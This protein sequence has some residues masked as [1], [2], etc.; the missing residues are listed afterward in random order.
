[1]KSY[2]IQTLGDS[3]LLFGGKIDAFALGAVPQSGVVDQNVLR[4]H[5]PPL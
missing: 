4:F 2:L 1:V 3:Q 5:N